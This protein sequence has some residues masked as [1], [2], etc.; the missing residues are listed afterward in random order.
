MLSQFV[1]DFLAASMPVLVPIGLGA[2]GLLLLCSCC[3]SFGRL[4]QEFAGHG[5]KL[6]SGFDSRKKS[7]QSPP[8]LFAK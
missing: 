2:A 5:L 8:R 7:G 4:A 6:N 1:G 3:G